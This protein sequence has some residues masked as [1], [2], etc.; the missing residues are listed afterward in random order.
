MPPFAAYWQGLDI[1][2][3]AEQGLLSFAEAER[4][5]RERQELLIALQGFLQHQGLLTDT[6]ADVAAVLSACLAFLGSSSAR[7]VLVNLEDLWL[8]TQPQN[9]PG[10]GYERPNW[11]H[12]ARYGLEVWR[13]MPQILATLRAVNHPRKQGSR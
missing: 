12:K 1:T 11:Q 4:E 9:F 7:V 6:P 2:D 13:T 8:E 5:H 10:T 3:R